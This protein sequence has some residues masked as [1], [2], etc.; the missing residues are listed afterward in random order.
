MIPLHNSTAHSVQRSVQTS[1]VHNQ[2]IQLHSPYIVS[3]KVYSMQALGQQRG[4]LWTVPTNGICPI[5][6][7]NFNTCLGISVRLSLTSHFLSTFQH[8]TCEILASLSSW[9]R[10]SR[11]ADWNSS[12]ALSSRNCSSSSDAGSRI[13]YTHDRPSVD[14]ALP[15]SNVAEHY[16]QCLTLHLNICSYR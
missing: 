5:F 10:P 11:F 9:M 4:C 8:L 14:T 12:S 16:K 6:S 2:Q 7:N 1:T 3:I 13:C 15:M